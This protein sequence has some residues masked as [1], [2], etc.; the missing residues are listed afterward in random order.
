VPEVVATV[1]P[2]A[3]DLPDWCVDDFETSYSH[4]MAMLQWMQFVELSMILFAMVKILAR[5]GRTKNGLCPGMAR[6][7]PCIF[8]ATV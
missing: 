5:R 7:P 8:F 2:G 1:R 3:T 6:F 4:G